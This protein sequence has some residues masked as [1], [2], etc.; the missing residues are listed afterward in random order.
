MDREKNKVKRRMKEERKRAEIE[1]RELPPIPGEE[2][3]AHIS[4]TSLPG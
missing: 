2:R 1:R 4:S 3:S